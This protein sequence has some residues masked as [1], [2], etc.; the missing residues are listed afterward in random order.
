LF[1]T[2]LWDQSGNFDVMERRLVTI[3]NCAILS[4]YTKICHGGG[5]LE[6]HPEVV[7]K[8]YAWVLCLQKCGHTWRCGRRGSYVTTFFFFTQIC[9]QAAMN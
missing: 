4:A 8:M 3:A 5:V 9:T 2:F 6:R 1:L 7:P